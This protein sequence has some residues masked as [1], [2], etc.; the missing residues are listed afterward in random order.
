M[1]GIQCPPPF[2]F[3]LHSYCLCNVKATVWKGAFLFVAA[4]VWVGLTYCKVI[5][6]SSVH[7][8]QQYLTAAITI[9][10]Y[11]CKDAPTAYTKV[12]ASCPWL[13]LCPCHKDFFFHNCSLLHA[14]NGSFPCTPASR[15]SSFSSVLWVMT[16]RWDKQD[17][18]I[19]DGFKVP[20]KSLEHFWQIGCVLK[21]NGHILS[22]W[23]DVWVF[24]VCAVLCLVRV[25]F[26]KM[27]KIKVI[28]L[29]CWKICKQ[30]DGETR[31]S[32]LFPFHIIIWGSVCAG[33]R[34]GCVLPLPSLP[35]S[36][37]PPSPSLPG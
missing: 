32:L 13:C 17:M 9:T 34:H 35:S 7:W 5:H 2:F 8:G 6:S 29:Q 4:T 14:E 22:C 36:L 3:F 28:Q 15:S 18:Q 19:A 1:G 31:K 10:L 33:A 26:K 37:P 27:T 21:S 30:F 11:I 12:S 20:I 23:K 25:C 16:S 24:Y